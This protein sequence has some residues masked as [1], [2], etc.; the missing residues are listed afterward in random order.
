MNDRELWDL[1]VPLKYFF[2]LKYLVFDLW[3]ANKDHG[4]DDRGAVRSQS[5]R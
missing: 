2:I 5:Y 3:F 1:K 4:A